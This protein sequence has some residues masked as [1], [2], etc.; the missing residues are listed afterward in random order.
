MRWFTAA[1]APCFA[2]KVEEWTDAHVPFV[3]AAVTAVPGAAVVTVRRGALT[4]RAEELEVRHATEDGVG[5]FA[6]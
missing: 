1:A 5:V 2:P 3:A 6:N 4:A